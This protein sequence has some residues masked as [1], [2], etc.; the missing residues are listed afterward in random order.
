[1]AA[2]VPAELR[3]AGGSSGGDGGTGPSGGE[4]KWKF[5]GILGNN[6]INIINKCDIA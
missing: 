1:V 4:A 2:A 6:N 3:A 5:H